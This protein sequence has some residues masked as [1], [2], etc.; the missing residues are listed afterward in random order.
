M[1]HPERIEDYL[2]HISE[3]IE[4]ATE[5]LS[6][7][8]NFEAFKRQRRDQ[9]AIIRNIEIIGEAARKI[10]QQAPDF[11]EAHPEVPWSHMRGMRN[12]VIHDYFDVEL[13][14]VWSTVKNDL[15]PLK[16]QIDRLLI[17][18]KRDPARE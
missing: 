16:Q 15:L 8:D 9:D 6:T 2:N 4:R 3:A 5:Y 11:V 10:Q 18:L 1:K 7:I 12:K 14:V 17:D 13:S